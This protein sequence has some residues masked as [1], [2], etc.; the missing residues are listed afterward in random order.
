VHVGR[1]LALEQGRVEFQLVGI[2]DQVR[3]LQLV[4]VFEQPVV[5]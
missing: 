4:L 2:A 1:Q 3:I 5:A